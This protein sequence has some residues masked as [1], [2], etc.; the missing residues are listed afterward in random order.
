MPDVLRPVNSLVW[1][2]K[3]TSFRILPYCI[4]IDAPLSSVHLPHM[5]TKTISIDLDA[6]RR[7]SA[8]RLGPKDSFSKVIKRAHWENGS[9]TCGDLLAALPRIPAADES[10]L[11]RLEAAQRQ[12]LPAD[13]HWS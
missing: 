7:L 6:Y 8:A 10:V 9:K 13:N 12:D 4:Q 5:A 3:K 2:T 11:Q 1:A